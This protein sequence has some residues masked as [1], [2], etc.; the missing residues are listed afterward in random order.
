MASEENPS[1]GDTPSR[2]ISPRTLAFLV[3]RL[4]IGAV[5][6]ASGLAKFA[7]SQKVF[8]ENPETG[9]MSASTLRSYSTEYYV[10]APAR[11]FDQLL[12]DP[13]LPDWVLNTFY[14][15]LGPSLIFFG[16]TLLLGLGT[17]ISLF[18]LGL[19]FI[20]LTFGLALID[21]SGSAGILGIYILAIAAALALADDNRFCLL[22]KF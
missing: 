8:E 7:Q 16:I 5:A 20:V 15:A 14:Y 11:E 2:R 3:L 19:I 12:G 10:G 22:Q 6:V 4:W 9:E 1:S 13:L 17:R 21:T 18:A